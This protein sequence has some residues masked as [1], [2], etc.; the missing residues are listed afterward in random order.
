VDATASTR[1]VGHPRS[2]SAFLRLVPFGIFV[3]PAI[4]RFVKT[5]RALNRHWELH[6]VQA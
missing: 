2:I 5:R 4:V 1:P 3:I 6:G